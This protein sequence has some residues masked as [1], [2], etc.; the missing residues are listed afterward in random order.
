MMDY[1]KGLNDEQLKAVRHT[2][3][4]L[5][6]IAGAGSG[7]TKMLVA[8]YAYLVHAVGIDP[9]SILCVTFTNK[10]AAEM[11][12]WVRKLIGEGYDTSLISTYHGFCVRLLRE[13]IE[14]IFYPSTFQI[15]DT[16][17][18]KAILKEIYEELEYKL[19]F[20]TFE[21]ILKVIS[22]YKN[23]H[24]YV[25]RMI[26]R[27]DDMQVDDLPMP[28]A[29][30]V[31][32]YLRKQKQVFCMDFDDLILFALHL[33]RTNAEVRDKWQQRLKLHP[34]RRVPGQFKA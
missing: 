8:R 13:D 34:G 31:S 5:R 11:R 10:A 4:F 28:E 32:R 1:L 16:T 20:A 17:D 18:Q 33:L 12:S 26:T 9:A 23:T 7:K 21:K 24:P 2:E 25:V 22:T 27:D 14:K 6:V 29:E 19:D 30:I 3:G 15:I